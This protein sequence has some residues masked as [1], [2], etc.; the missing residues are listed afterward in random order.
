MNINVG[1]WLIMR[2]W[3]TIPSLLI[4]VLAIGLIGYFL[5]QASTN[6]SQLI[7]K[8]LQGQMLK[9]VSGDLTARLQEAIQLNQINYDAYKSGVLDLNTES[10]RER[11]FVSHLKSFPDAAMT[12]V[13]LKDGSFY[14]ARRAIDGQIQV[15]RNNSSTNGGSW[16]YKISDLGDGT[17]FVEKFDN[18]DPRK[19]PWYLAA[20]ST[21][22]PTFS[23]VYSH[24][25]YREPTIT[26][27][28]PLYDENQQLIGVFGVDYL[29]SWLGD[30]LNSLPIGASGQVFVMDSEGQLI[31]TTAEIPTYQI[32]DGKSVLISADEIENELIHGALSVSV[33]SD[34]KTLPQFKIEDEKYYVGYS[35]Y[36]EYGLDWN[37]YVI[38]A[39]N[40]FLLDFKR[41]TS[42]TFIILAFAMLISIFF[43]S[44]IAG[45]VTK[46][47]TQLSNAAEAL[48]DGRLI[49]LEDHSR[50]DEL[51]KLMRNFNSMGEQ[52]TNLV[53]H[54]EEEV[55]ER[56]SE[57]EERNR[58]LSLLSFSD[59]LTGIANRRKFDE[60]LLQ[61][62]KTEM[63]YERPVALL[64]LDIDVFKDYNDF[65]GHVAGDEC[66]KA[67]AHYLH[68]KVRRSSDLAARYGGEEFVVLI[69]EPDI[70]KL[71]EYADEI[72]QGIEDLKIEHE[73]S[74][75]KF[76]TVSIGA[77]YM[78]P[79][80]NSE[81]D[82]LIELADQMLYQAKDS[83]R[84]QVAMTWLQGDKGTEILSPEI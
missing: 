81:P 50:H 71:K 13:G 70:E 21:G 53:A 32:V 5:L 65:Y 63:R 29:L 27:S 79:S 78:V 24:F 84:N 16:Y 8:E 75:Y 9:Q 72:R 26:Y 66:L 11:Y 39:D 17:D 58:E 82:T 74:P 7:L 15:V 73:S 51:G 57:L 43:T 36:I 6:S 30:T 69:Q 44:W 19:R 35:S 64:M 80:K 38:S 61:S 46:P 77:A 59:G 28:Y 45:R 62:W 83:G 55:A 52:L 14:G 10:I 1:E 47:I 76:V 48:M 31:A 34:E 68:T 41:A 54:L 49:P 67:I 25:I 3:F 4:L 20:E 56:T 22:A 40:D 42:Q 37:I 33:T 12:Y 23:S 60:M 18:F 2:K